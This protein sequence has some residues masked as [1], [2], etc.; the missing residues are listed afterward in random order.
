MLHLFIDTSTERAIL[1]LAHNG[2]LIEEVLL[3]QGLKNSKLLFP[4]LLELFDRQKITAKD[5]SLISCGVGPGSYTGIRVGAATAQ[6]M[7]YALRLPLIGISS[8]EAFAPQEDGVFAVLL[9]AKIS[10]VYFQKGE[11]KGESVKF[12]CTPKAVPLEELDAELKGVERILTPNKE[13]I[14][15]IWKGRQIV[16]EMSPSGKLFAE[17]AY[18]QYSLGHYSKKAELKL[19][20]LRATEAES[21]LAR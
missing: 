20:Y 11:R 5:I 4:A 7:A 8:L 14:C 16:E 12:L 17:R 19:L 1:G 9:D 18:A 2:E 15:A 10:G 6:S 3:P 21:N 13:A